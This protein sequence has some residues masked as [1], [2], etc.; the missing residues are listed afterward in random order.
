MKKI[1]LVIA[2][3]IL[4]VSLTMLV[5]GYWPAAREA[6]TQPISSSEMQLPVP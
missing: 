3:L 1:R 2:I 5:W 4:M 6:R